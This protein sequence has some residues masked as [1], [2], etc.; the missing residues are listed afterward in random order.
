MKKCCFIV[1]Y[2]GKMPN[3]FPIF[4]RSC[5]KNIDYE[6]LFFTDDKTAYAYPNNVKVIYSSFD[7][8]VNAI[9]KKLGFKTKILQPHKL[10]DFKP[11]YGFIFEEYLSDYM[12]WGFCDI[13]LIFGNLNH[14][15]SDYILEKYDKIFVLGHFQMFKNSQCN[16]RIFMR[17]VKGELWYKDSFLVAETTVFDE[18]GKGFKNINT[19]FKFYNRKIFEED[20]SM[21]AQIAPANFFRTQ[22]DYKNEKFKREKFKYALYIWNGNNGGLYRYYFK[23]LKFYREE[24][25]YMHFQQRNM[26]IF[27][28]CNSEM[29]K[30]LGNG[31]YSLNNRELNIYNFLREKKLIYSFRYI[32]I[33]GKWKI[34]GLIKRVK[35]MIKN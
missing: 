24:F 7:E 30:V 18:V 9:E 3:Y 6:W 10:C 26:N 23:G 29:I 20:F 35:S 11:A 1:P 4:L 28:D 25:L 14:F 17:E 16:N 27:C 8:F 2:F 5:E 19:I 34:S 15:I 12:F 13:D 21:N 31:F 32:K 22:Y 33:M